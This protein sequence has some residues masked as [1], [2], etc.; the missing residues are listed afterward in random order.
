MKLFTGYL[1]AEP[2][3]RQD[4]MLV[5]FQVLNRLDFLN[6]V[7]AEGISTT[8]ID[9]QA[10]QI[11]STNVTTSHS[12]VGR[13][14]KVLKGSSLATSIELEEKQDYSITQLNEYNLP[15]KLTLNSALLSGEHIYVSYIYWR[16]GLLIDEMVEDLLDFV[17]IGPSDRIVDPV[18]FSNTIR[19]ADTNFDS[20]W[21]WVFQRNNN[22]FTTVMSGGHDGSQNSYTAAYFSRNNTAHKIIGCYCPDISVKF[23]VSRLTY[24]YPQEIQYGVRFMLRNSLG[25]DIGFRFVEQTIQIYAAGSATTVGNGVSGNTFEIRYNPN[26]SLIF[27]KNGN[28]IYSTTISSGIII[29]SIECYPIVST[30]LARIDDI[31]AKPLADSEYYRKPYI[32]LLNENTDSSFAQYDRLNAQFEVTNVPILRVYVRY[33]NQGEQWSEFIPYTIETPLNID[34]KILEF[35]IMNDA[36]FSNN[37]NLKNITLWHYQT[38]DVPLGVCNLTNMSVLEA[39]KQLAS[40]SMYEIGFDSDDKFFFRNRNRAGEIRSLYDNEIIEMISINNNLDRLKTKVVITYGNYSKVIDCNTQEEEHPNNVD[41]Y[42]TRIYELSGGQLLPPDNVDLTF[43]IAPTVYEELSKLRLNV[44]VDIKMNLELELGDYVK[45]YHNNILLAKES[46][47]DYT[48]WLELGIYGRKFKVEGIS[49]NFNSKITT[50]TL[51]DYSTE[52]DI[53]TPE[54]NDF[55]YNLMMEFDRKK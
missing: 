35:I 36:S 32:K 54:S 15:A 25:V 22:N 6:T 14:T 55:K 27:L 50:L 7:S 12:A 3:Y 42:G 16:K 9:E 46:F 24:D 21:S 20:N 28:S 39:L 44:K 30:T 41:L 33:K 2:T 40:M 1:T 49:T 23:K 34:K 17:N 37:I 47:T 43:A 18:I 11:D 48:K 10:T 29:T 4:E 45:L 26:G 52:E 31:E 53:P 5:E 38:T 13:I 51:T 19:V 8:I